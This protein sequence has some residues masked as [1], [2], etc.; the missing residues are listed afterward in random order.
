MVRRQAPGYAPP[1][2]E[3]GPAAGYGTKQ[4]RFRRPGNNLNECYLL[5][6]YMAL[7][8]ILQGGSMSGHPRGGER[9]TCQRG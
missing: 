8:M 7:K 4:A 6:Y 5:A 1:R 2:P 9:K 3:K